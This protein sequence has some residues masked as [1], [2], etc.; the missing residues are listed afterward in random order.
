VQ[1]DECT[2]MSQTTLSR[3]K[4]HLVV[5]SSFIVGQS[6]PGETHSPTSVSKYVLMFQLVTVW[7][8]RT[9]AYHITRVW[10]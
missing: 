5:Y 4:Q 10:F 1:Y 3:S 6:K 9:I 8:A 2:E 7:L